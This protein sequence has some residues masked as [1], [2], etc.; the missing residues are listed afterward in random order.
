MILVLL[1]L[2]TFFIQKS[3]STSGS[4]RPKKSIAEQLTGYNYYSKITKNLECPISDCQFKFTNT[5]LLKRHL[6]GSKHK[7]DVKSFEL[8][9]NDPSISP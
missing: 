3:R 9:I 2:T 7:E 4:P 6:E 5:Y 8:A 1:F